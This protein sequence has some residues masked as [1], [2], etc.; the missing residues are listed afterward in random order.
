MDGLRAPPT[1]ASAEIEKRIDHTRQLMRERGLSALALTGPEDIYYLTGLD[2]QGYFAFTLLVVPLTRCPLVVARA[3]EAWTI[4]AMAPGVEHVPYGDDEHSSWAAARAVRHAVPDTGIVGID[5]SG[6]WMPLAVWDELQVACPGV[7]YVD[8][9]GLVEGLRQVKSDLEIEYVRQAA[10]TSSQAMNAGIAAI[11]SGVTERDVARRVYDALLSAG[12]EHPG[13]VPLIRTRDRL[14]LEHC[15]WTNR[16]LAYGDAVFLELSGS[17]ARYHA[18]LSRIVHVGSTPKGTVDSAVLAAAGME[19]VRAALVPGA[20]SGDV[21]EAWQDV[22]DTGLGHKRYRRH[23]CGYLIGIGFPPSWVGGGSVVGLR[24]GGDLEIKAGMVFHVLSW[25]MGQHI[26]DY[27]L[28]DSIL[29]TPYGGEIL[30]NAPWDPII[31]T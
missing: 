17:V 26:P 12:S 16:T 7:E 28:S 10:E 23:H 6:M 3:M 11:T 1:P 4:A 24:R 2:H 20:V 27:M 30:T 9:S 19:A 13:F 8:G 5:R 29:V 31:T 15:T 21:Y 18:P 25:L 14:S 22:V